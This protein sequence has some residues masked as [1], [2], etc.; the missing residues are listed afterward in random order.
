[1]NDLEK[2]IEV[3]KEISPAIE[4]IRNSLKEH[5][6]CSL[7]TLAIAADGY[8]SGGIHEIKGVQLTRCGEGTLVVEKCER[9]EVQ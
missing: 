8:V 5:G 1:M 3:S 4:T 7:L 2:F 6:I 9:Y